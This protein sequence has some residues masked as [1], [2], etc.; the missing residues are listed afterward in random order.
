[1][2]GKGRKKYYAVRVGHKPGLYNE[3]SDVEKQVM[4]YKGAEYNSLKRDAEKYL[5]SKKKSKYGEGDHIA[6]Q[7]D[8]EN[9]RHDENTH[10]NPQDE[11]PEVIDMAP[12]QEN[13]NNYVVIDEYC[14]SEELEE[15][16][17][18]NKDDL[19]NLWEGF[20]L[21]WDYVEDGEN[22][23][24]H[25]EFI[26]KSLQRTASLNS[27]EREEDCI[28]PTPLPPPPLPPSPPI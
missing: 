7:H 5:K 13:E 6:D 24:N 10:S 15:K 1:M 21:L 4:S 19:Q 11:I 12:I 9:Q 8:A 16:L 28:R 22:C 27:S 26:L 14:Y 20:D 18:K 3:W 17:M 23:L 25:I 2:P